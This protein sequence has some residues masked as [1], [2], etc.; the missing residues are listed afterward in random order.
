ME[1]QQTEGYIVNISNNEHNTKGGRYTT[2]ISASY[3]KLNEHSDNTSFA[4][5]VR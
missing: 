5:W 4:H 1:S 2:N 3:I